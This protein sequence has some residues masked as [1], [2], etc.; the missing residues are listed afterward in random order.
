M[1]YTGSSTELMELYAKAVESL[2][3]ELETMT[4]EEVADLITSHDHHDLKQEYYT[5]LDLMVLLF[6]EKMTRL[7]R[8]GVIDAL[9]N[10]GI[11][12]VLDGKLRLGEL[13]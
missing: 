5:V 8:E 4:L 1:G 12:L 9:S 3:T 13:L 11:E 2:Y 10:Q 7:V 6:Y